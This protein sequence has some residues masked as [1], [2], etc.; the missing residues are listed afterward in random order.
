[1]D[2]KKNFS[3]DDKNKVVQ[4][5]NHVA[6]HATFEHKTNEAIEFYRLLSY[7]QQNLI[8]KID[9]NCLEVKKIIESQQAAAEDKGE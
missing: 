8:P 5:L 4:F 1:M 9:A 6:K 7:M 2:P 3:E